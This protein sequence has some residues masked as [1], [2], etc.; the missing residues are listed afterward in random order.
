MKFEKLLFSK[1]FFYEIEIENC[2]IV[3]NIFFVDF[4][5]IW[6]TV[7]FCDVISFQE[8]NNNFLEKISYKLHFLKTF[9]NVDYYNAIIS[10]NIVG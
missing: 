3:N 5:S 10:I 9:L 7:Y 6:K 4:P 2:E 8:D 1:V